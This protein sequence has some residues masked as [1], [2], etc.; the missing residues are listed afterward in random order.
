MISAKPPSSGGFVVIENNFLS[1]FTRMDIPVYIFFIGIS[2]IAS[3]INTFKN[4]V[5][6]LYLK[7][8]P[9]YLGI[10]FI[11]ESVGN[12]RWSR[13][14]TT[15]HLYSF[16]GVF[17]F[18]FYSFILHQS[19]HSKKARLMV[20]VLMV[21]YPVVVLLNVLFIQI[22]GFHSITYALGCLIIVSMCIYYFLELFQSPN[23]IELTREPAFWICTALLFFYCCTFP[24]FSLTNF[25]RNLPK[26]I[27][28][29]IS[30]LL[31]LMNCLLY[32]LFTIAFLCRIRIRKS[33]SLS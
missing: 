14:L 3:A 22:E 30:A 4:P 33:M 6:K 12:Y 18:L 23:S 13:G 15:D 28:N 8:F 24:I 20:Q 19:L 9:F 32:S 2:F 16:F 29:N 21:L 10:T 11:I 31:N 25:I 26:V 17:E 27:I 1:L 7:A 5:D